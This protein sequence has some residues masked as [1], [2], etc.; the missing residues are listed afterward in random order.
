MAMVVMTLDISPDLGELSVRCAEFDQFM[1]DRWD[2]LA[3]RIDEELG[4]I[5]TERFDQGGPADAP[6]PPSRRVLEVGGLTLVKTGVL[7]DS[8]GPGAPLFG[9]RRMT[10]GEELSLMF[11]TNVEY[12]V[13]HQFGYPPRNIPARPFLGVEQT[14]MGRI[15]AIGESW[16]VEILQEYITYLDN[17]PDGGPAA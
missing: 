15:H 10:K 14:Q 5:H 2:S 13:T 17:T 12:G 7:R 6:W 1:K 3:I 9:V 16:A 4:L 11:G 8:V